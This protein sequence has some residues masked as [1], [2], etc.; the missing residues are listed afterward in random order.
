MP[1]SI[2]RD[3]PKGTV[4]PR[5]R[6]RGPAAWLATLALLVAA[7]LALSARADVPRVASDIPPVHSLVATV[8][9]ELGEPA[10]LMRAGSSPHGYAMRP[11]EAA[12]LEASD[13]VFWTSAA[14]TPWLAR[15]IDKLAPDARSIELMAV[16]GT[17]RRYAGDTSHGHGTAHDHGTEHA[18]ADG[19]DPHGWLD[20]ANARL[21]LDA[22]ADA[23]ARID[24]DNADVYA[25]NAAAG[26][27][28]L[29]ALIQRT[30]ARLE[31]VRGRPFVVFH[32]SL[33]YFEDRFGL[34]AAAAL[35]PTD[36]S[37]ASP[38][39]VQAVRELMIERNVVC[40]FTEPQLDARRA[41]VLVDGLDVATGVLDPL[42]ATLEPGPALYER[43]VDDVSAALV[44][45]LQER[46]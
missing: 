13:V 36:A 10:L 23:L 16:D 39:R 7:P 21:W 11:S 4:L 37:P 14:L 22:I 46:A 1:P 19:V 8:M 34:P 35:S 40:V 44:A 32:D 25:A 30:E 29:D 27:A 15:E 6:A 43:L 33:G 24:P 9:G 18:G 42:G 12:A 2:L 26:R 41:R 5:R 28:S 31:A 45:C 38:A 3:R 17:E 20:P